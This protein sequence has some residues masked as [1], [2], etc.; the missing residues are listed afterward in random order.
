M[1]NDLKE[2]ID[3]PEITGYRASEFKNLSDL[4]TIGYSVTFALAGF[5]AFLWFTSGAIL[6]I[7]AKGDKEQLG[8][9]RARMT[10]A[11]IGLFFIILAY[12]I[13]NFAVHILNP[14]GGTPL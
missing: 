3:N 9:A 12:F 10:W 5:L 2:L 14:K 11:M 13:A 7:L 4:V 8:R 1:I 6:Y